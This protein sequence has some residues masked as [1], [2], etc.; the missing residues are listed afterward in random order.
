L[1][2][3]LKERGAIGKDRSF[4]SWRSTN[5]TEAQKG[6]VRNYEPGMVVEFKEAVAGTRRRLNGV[7]VTSG[8]FKKGEAVIV[9][10]RVDEGLNVMRQDGTQ[11]LLTMENS[12]R[13]NAFIPREIGIAKGDRIRITKN[14]E[15]K[16]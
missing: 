8:G 6:D 3:I 14:G 11:G 4:T 16:V 10:G 7:R 2:G 13:I 9:T 1:R 5:W 15:P 12:G